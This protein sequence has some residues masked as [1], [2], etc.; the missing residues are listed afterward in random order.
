MKARVGIVFLLI[1][2]AVAGLS[3]VSGK[4][5]G[6]KQEASQQPAQIPAI[7][8]ST[9]ISQAAAVYGV[10]PKAIKRPFGLH[11]PADLGKT[12]FES[13][14]T[15]AQAE[16]KLRK[17][18]VLAAEE[19]TKNW[20]KIPL[21]F[22]LWLIFLIVVF[23]LLRRG[24]ITPSLRKGLLLTA[25]GLFGIILGADPSPMGT[26][27]DAIVLW[28]KEHV[29]FPPRLVAFAVFTLSVILA[30]KF[31]CS[32]GCQLGTLQDLIFRINRNSADTEGL[33][34]Q[35]KP[36][37][38]LTNSIR[39][40]TFIALCF[41]AIAAGT[42]II[43]PVDPFRIYSP[44]R[45][46]VIGAGFALLMLISSLFIYRPWCHFFCPFGL[47]GWLFERISVNKIRV[48][49]KTCVSCGECA[50]AC[51]SMAMEAILRK[52]SMKPD[53]FSCGT[54]QGVCPTKSIYFGRKIQ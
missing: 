28:G 22:A 29:I 26:I 18:R 47:T 2:I 25:V 3:L 5:W 6:G 23:R 35:W 7:Y 30:N 13:G 54:C 32:W 24:A 53:C 40:A 46:G 15:V 37:F 52:C 33:T 41:F 39:I 20:F 1:V 50:K 48:N 36:P 8:E 27:K 17:A 38:A 9:T 16:E 4:I 31:I 19:S 12:I 21:K 44:M 10:N 43:A 42:D 14:L 45:L 51:P 11:S 34:R 49:R